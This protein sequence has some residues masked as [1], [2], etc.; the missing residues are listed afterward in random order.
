MPLVTPVFLVE[1]LFSVRHFPL[2][3]IV[4]NEEPAG[5]EAF[6]FATLRRADHWSPST[7]NAD[8]NLKVTCNRARAADFLCL[9]DHNLQGETLRIECSDDD[10]G[11]TQTIF[12]AVLPTISGTGDVDDALGVLTEDGMWLK[13]FPLRSAKYWRLFVPAMG[14]NQKPSINGLLGL[15]YGLTQY[16]YPFAP[17]DTELI[18]EE[19][20]SEAGYLGRSSPM[21]RRGGEITVKCRSDFDYELA[22]YHLEQR[23]GSGSPMLIVHDDAQAERAAMAVRPKGGRF[24]FRSDEQWPDGA[25]GRRIGQFPWLEWEPAEVAA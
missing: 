10:F 5:T 8:A 24:G 7:F 25:E 12:N 11:T 19:S 15:S 4:G 22:R 13:R 9:W 2:H 16:D 17:S 23:F 6:R 21:A 18:V 14:A 20:E 1:S 3:T